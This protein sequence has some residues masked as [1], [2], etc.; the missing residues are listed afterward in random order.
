MRNK[1]EISPTSDIW[2]SDDDF[3]VSYYFNGL[4]FHYLKEILDMRV[5]DLMNM[6]RLDAIRVEEIIVCLY[7][8]L[9]ENS[10][11]DKA[12]YDG[13]MEQPYDFRVW[14]KKKI[15][16]EDVTVNDIVMEPQTNIDVVLHLYDITRRHFFAS[17]EYNWKEYLYRNY[18]EY[19]DVKKHEKDGER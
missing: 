12:L 15:K 14:K 4:G 6:N 5:F 13:T 10:G 18:K 9:N 16:W 11:V 1:L 17:K 19:L 3:G 7:K 2:L 8:F